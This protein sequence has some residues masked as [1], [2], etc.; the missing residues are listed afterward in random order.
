[1]SDLLDEADPIPQSYTLEVGSPG[2][3][4]K[5]TKDW[6]FQKYLGEPVLVRLIRPVEGV[7]DFVGELAAYHEDG[8][9]DLALDEES[10]MSFTL[11]ETAYVRLY[12][13][14]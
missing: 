4:R 13:E 1:M 2:V 5:L 8:T 12:E 9:I 10:E 6:H 11:D 3:E 7:R 14:F